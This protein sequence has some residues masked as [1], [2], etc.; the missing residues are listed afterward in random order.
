MPANDAGGRAQSARC[1]ARSHL[2]FPRRAA[3]FGFFIFLH[4]VTASAAAPGGASA[5]KPSH[6][7]TAWTAQG[8]LSLGDVFA[9]AED[10]DGYLWLGTSNGLVRFDGA[11]FTRTAI[12]TPARATEGPVSALVGARDG[13]LW[14]GSA[15]VL[16]RMRTDGV[17]HFSPGTVP[18]PGSVAALLEDRTGTVWAGGRGGVSAFR[19]GR[20]EPV[21]VTPALGDGTVYSIYED[22]DGLLWLGTSNGVY[23]NARHGF[24]L[25]FA[26]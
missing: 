26:E 8:D 13:S 6:T 17:V 11:V 22:R 5:E 21:T 23:A 9:I 2:S 19:D 12:G 7:L 20:W 4:A 15:G 3:A 10:R 1:R 16:V 24:E 14:V 25:R 18:L